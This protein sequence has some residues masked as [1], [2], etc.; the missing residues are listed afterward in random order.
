MTQQNATATRVL[1]VCAA[2]LVAGPLGAWDVRAQPVKMARVAEGTGRAGEFP[3]KWTL[4]H[5]IP[6]SCRL[7]PTT[8]RCSECDRCTPT[9]P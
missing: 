6:S 5:A 8:P 4:Y 2:I 3:T 9:D 1:L 7:R